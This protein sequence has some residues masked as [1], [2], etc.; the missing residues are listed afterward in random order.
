MEPE[1][2]IGTIVGDYDTDFTTRTA[3]AGPS[4]PP[5][6]RFLGRRFDIKDAKITLA[7]IGTYWSQGIL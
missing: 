4:E 2:V 5:F 7:Q 3:D 6:L 1:P